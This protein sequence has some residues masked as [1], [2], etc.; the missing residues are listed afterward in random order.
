MLRRRRSG[1]A[2]LHLPEPVGC[3]GDSQAG[4]GWGAGTL[5]TQPLLVPSPTLLSGGPCAGVRF[6][7]ILYPHLCG[8]WA[9]RSSQGGCSGDG[10]LIWHPC[11]SRDPGIGIPWT[12]RAVEGT[13]RDSPITPA[14]SGG[15]PA[16]EQEEQPFGVNPLGTRLWAMPNPCGTGE[17]MSSRS[18][19]PQHPRD[20]A[21]P[22]AMGPRGLRCCLHRAQHSAGAGNAMPST[23]CCRSCGQVKDLA[24]QLWGVNGG[25]GL[26]PL[27]PSI[28]PLYLEGAW[29]PWWHCS[30]CWCDADLSSSGKGWDGTKGEIM[31]KME[32]EDESYIGCPQGLEAT[33]PGAP[34]IGEQST[35]SSARAVAPRIESPVLDQVPCP[36]TA[37]PGST[38][39]PSLPSTGIKAEVIGKSEDED[40]AYGIY[41][42]GSPRQDVTP[43]D[44]ACEWGEGYRGTQPGGMGWVS[45][46][47]GSSWAC[48]RGSHPS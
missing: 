22:C 30:Q 11:W 43:L 47:V 6:A 18:W 28:V 9:V 4:E 40:V 29:S 12:P 31:V 36:V 7:L 19:L 2:G 20:I 33:G 3:S 46:A 13:G 42:S 45:W 1:T 48:T 15:T 32:P 10:G 35:W 23:G 17:V 16:M 38:F 44:M 25:P 8:C 27:L 5:H 21:A 37:A 26:D 14:G 39:P 41:S 34:G 24:G